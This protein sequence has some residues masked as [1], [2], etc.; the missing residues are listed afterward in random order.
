MTRSTP[1]TRTEE[2]FA[3]LRADVLNGRLEPG[4]RLK[5]AGLC[6]R[7]SVSLSVVREAL[8]RLAE[9]GLLVANPQRG[10]SV[11]ALS[12]DDLGDL[13]RVRVQIES[14]ALRQSLAHGDLAWET[15]VLG[16]HHTLSRTPTNGLDGRFNEEW[17]QVHSDFH[18][19]L[20]AG[21]GSPRLEE[22]AT[23]LR[24]SA[25]LYRRWYWALTDDHQRDISAEHEL[26]K[27]LALARDADRAVEVLQEHIERAPRA[28][29]AYI[30]E[31][32][33][34]STTPA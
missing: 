34:I 4:R 27:D 28:L 32:G 12:A 17:P 7:F 16:R 9:Q 5:L 24:D 1:S 18:R 13:T 33:A 21:S 31:H 8:I 23:G 19:A 30:R 25:E 6:E 29:F 22:I 14:L 10:F 26:L 15:L 11:R 2:V 3:E 20:L